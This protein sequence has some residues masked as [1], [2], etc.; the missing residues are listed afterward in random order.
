MVMKN[1]L[2]AGKLVGLA[3]GGEDEEG[4]LRIT[5]YGELESLLE[6]AVLPL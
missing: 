2:M 1:R 3:G 4:D 6:K 5:E